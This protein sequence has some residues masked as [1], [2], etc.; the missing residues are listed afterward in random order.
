MILGNL[1]I[2]I[3]ERIGLVFKGRKVKKINSGSDLECSKASRE[4]GD[5]LNQV[6]I[7]RLN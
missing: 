6:L 5:F 1:I 4:M 7:F 3:N 2:M